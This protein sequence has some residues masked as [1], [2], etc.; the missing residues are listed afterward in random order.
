[1]YIILILIICAV[2]SYILY[3]H[4]EKKYLS[5]LECAFGCICLLCILGICELSRYHDSVYSGIE[6]G[7][8]ND[9]TIYILAVLDE[10]HCG[11]L[12]G[13]ASIPINFCP[14]CGRDLRDD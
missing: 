3:R 7:L 1:M 9:G 6:V 14:M 5:G 13:E 4:V 11:P 8:D 10:R 12:V 2:L